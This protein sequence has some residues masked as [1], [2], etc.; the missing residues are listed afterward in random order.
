MTLNF[1]ISQMAVL[2]LL[3]TG[4]A[5]KKKKEVVKVLND[6]DGT[7]LVMSGGLTRDPG[8]HVEAFFTEANS[9]SSCFLPDLP[10]DRNY[11]TLDFI[12]GRLVLCGGDGNG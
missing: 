5:C 7:V 12:D 8:R 11:N 3:P 9:S 2:C 10:A 1:S 4:E 6:D